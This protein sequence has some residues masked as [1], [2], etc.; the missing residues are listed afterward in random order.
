MRQQKIIDNRITNQMQNTTKLT[1][2]TTEQLLEQKKKLTGV[3][4]GLGVVMLAAAI[5][6]VYRAVV[7]NQPAFIAIAIGCSVSFLP[8]II[9]LGQINTELKS[10]SRN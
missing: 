1:D 3:T 10:R 2:L 6:L 9:R 8:T 5:F 4:I 7:S